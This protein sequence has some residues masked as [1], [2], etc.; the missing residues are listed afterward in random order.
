[1]ANNFDII[2]SA[3]DIIAANPK[4]CYRNLYSKLYREV[5][6]KNND[7]KLDNIVENML[8]SARP[9]CGYDCDE[10]C[11]VSGRAEH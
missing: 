10:L 4:M 9:G 2:K 3:V 5:L 7:S 6:S 1:M 8:I 11:P